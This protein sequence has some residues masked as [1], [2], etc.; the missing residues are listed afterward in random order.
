[1]SDS[2]FSS[3]PQYSADD[4][5][6]VAC[7]FL[8]WGD[9]GNDGSPGIWFVGLEEGGE[10]WK[11]ETVAKYRS[12]VSRDC[13]FEVANETPESGSGSVD[14]WMS[15]IDCSL[16]VLDVPPSLLS[17]KPEPSVSSARR[18]SRES[19]LDGVDRCGV[20][21]AASWCSSAPSSLSWSSRSPSSRPR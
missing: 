1:M 7:S 15:K 8:G 12:Q 2:S 14:S 19:G 21:F 16:T 4:N 11:E 9:P 3:W 10:A 17:W 18:R 5:F 13:V 6:G 20:F